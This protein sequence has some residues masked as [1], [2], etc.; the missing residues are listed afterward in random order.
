MGTGG[1][2]HEPARPAEAVA[3]GTASFR[4]GSVTTAAD[5]V[6]GTAIAAGS[7]A[8]GTAAT[9]S[10]AFGTRSAARTAV[11]APALAEF[12]DHLGAAHAFGQESE[13]SD[14][15]VQIGC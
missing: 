2:A 7:A 12:V 5:V 11:L 14:S 10:S 6:L 3:F 15:F 13:E 4:G 8:P 1:V 9:G